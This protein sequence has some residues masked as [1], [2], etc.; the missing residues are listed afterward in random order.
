MRC[1]RRRIAFTLG[2][3]AI[4]FVVAGPASPEARESAATVHESVLVRIEPATNRVSR[5]VEVGSGPAAAAVGGR[6]VWVYN[7]ADRTVSEIDA[8]T[9][10]VRRSTFVSALPVD[11]GYTAGPV[12][13]ADAGG[14]WLVGLD[15]REGFLLTRVPRG[16]G[17]IRT[18]AL[19]VEPRAVAVGAGAVWVL[20]HRPGDNELL[21]LNGLTGEVTGRTWFPDAGRVDSLDVGLGAV[22]VTSSTPAALYRVDADTMEF[23]ARADLGRRA[24]RPRVRFGLV[25]V[26]ISDEGGR[27]LLLDGRTL[28]VVRVL[29]CCALQDGDDSVRGFGSS[30]TTDREAG[31]VVRRDADTYDLVA[32]IHLTPPPSAG[33]LCETAMTAGD[34]AVWV[35]LGRAVGHRCAARR[36]IR[37]AGG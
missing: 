37:R 17:P 28:G 33:V 25:W 4:P 21:R 30:W 1:T 14:A 26:R 9:S 36:G 22:F 29:G 8:D 27:T 35:T 3:V 32:T 12:L 13:A 16:K 23:D 34:G 24:G 10:R 18:Y 31:T 20:G 11:L 6:T 5:V 19:N 15:E 2:I 7:D